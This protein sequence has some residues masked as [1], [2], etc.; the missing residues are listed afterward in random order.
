MIRDLVEDRQSWIVWQMVAEGR[1]LQKLNWKLLAKNEHT[2]G[3]N[4]LRIYSKNLKGMHE[5]I[6]KIISNQ[7]DIKLG[8]F[9]Q[10][11]LD[12]ILRKI[13]NK[14]AA[15]LDEISPEVWKTKIWRHNPLTL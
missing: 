6:T 11:E 7:L 8:Q 2:C 14:K 15:W 13:K 10:E 9:T 1:V 4:I 12:S 5:P 3:T